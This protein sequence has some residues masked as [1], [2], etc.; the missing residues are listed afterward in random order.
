MRWRKWGFSAKVCLAASTLSR[1]EGPMQ[2]LA[3][4]RIIDLTRVIAG[5]Y[6]AF[7]L[8]LHGADCIKVEEPGTGDPVRWSGAGSTEEYRR[9]GMATNFLPQNANKRAMT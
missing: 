8:A 2:A 6:C 9:R 5:P 1:R 3:G 4:V 7:Q